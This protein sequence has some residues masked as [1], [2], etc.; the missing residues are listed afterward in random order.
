[1]SDLIPPHGGR[2]TERLV[3]GAERE[4]LL[5]ESQR[6][7]SIT[8]DDWELADLEM[9]GSGALSPLE[10]FLREAEYD[11]VVDRMQLADGAVWP[12]PVTLSLTDGEAD[13]WKEGQDLRLEAPDG[14]LIG[15]LHQPELYPYNRM[16]EAKLV[17]GT[18]DASHPGVARILAQGPYY[19][20]GRVSVVEMPPHEDFPEYR[21][22]P[23]Q[24]RQEFDRRGWRHVV[25]FQLR[26][27]VHR[28][29]EY[30]LRCA[31]EIAD[32]V[33]IHPAVGGGEEENLPASVRVRCIRALL[34]HYFPLDRA[35]LVVNPL[36][37]R[38]GGPREAI[39]QAILRQNYGCSHFIIGRDS[40]SVGKFYGPMDSQRIFEK[41]RPEQL[42]VTPLFF[43]NAF[44]CR[45]CQGM[46]T[47]KSC[48]HS[49]SERGA[50]S[51]AVVDQFLMEGKEPPP[52]FMR[53]EVSEIL[54]EA[55]QKVAS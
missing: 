23:A 8:L 49:L 5:H 3:R 46:A 45:T 17:Y 29:Q 32:G 21:L 42:A 16:V 37:M 2:L 14:R 18:T 53:P 11:S 7:P 35:L 22:T 15:I 6:L 40:T 31:L 25:G 43:D 36:S 30:L 44:Y 24:T 51:G 54:R 33:M 19:V 34:D 55:A 52:E 39:F 38:Y 28:A 48:G 9:L 20:G 26:G 4:A 27:V 10:G 41:F 47:V 13:L 1:M 50:I 12:L